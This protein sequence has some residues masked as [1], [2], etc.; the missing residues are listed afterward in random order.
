MMALIGT[1]GCAEAQGY[2]VGHPGP[3]PVMEPA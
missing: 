1:L 2:L 3:V